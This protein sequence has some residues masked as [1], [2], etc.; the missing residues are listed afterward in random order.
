MALLKKIK[1]RLFKACAPHSLSKEMSDEDFLDTLYL[2]I[3]ERH[4]DETGKNGFLEEMREGKLRHEV[5]EDLLASQE[6]ETLF[7]RN[8]YVIQE[9]IS[10][11][12]DQY[13]HSEDLFNHKK[14]PVFFLK[15][16]EDFDWLEQRILE[17]HYY[18]R[19]DTPWDIQSEADANILAEII[20]T[21]EPETVLEL[22]CSSGKLLKTLQDQGFRVKGIDISQNAIDNSPD[23]V[24]SCIIIQDVNGYSFKNKV[25]LVVAMDLF[26]HLN[27]NRLPDLLKRIWQG[28]DPGGYVICNIPAFGRDEIFGEIFPFFLE[29]WVERYTV[30][31]IFK[32]IKVDRNG[33][34]YNGHLISAGTQWWVNQFEI[35]GF[36]RDL[37]KGASIHAQFSERLKKIS[38]ARLS[39]FVFGK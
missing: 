24:K 35:A 26:E 19:K 11:R 9:I 10:E 32:I 17:N 18:E 25:D 21:F 31:D 15:N 23:E 3:L 5:V 34:P 30:E 20:G 36:T 2:A 29:E 7:R 6:F 14:T 39:L 27:P 12:T 8:N 13:S 1:D 16:D 37:S 33:Y 22:G 4:P 38:L 28:L